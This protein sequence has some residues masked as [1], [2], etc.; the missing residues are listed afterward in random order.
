ML[1]ETE[2]NKDGVLMVPIHQVRDALDDMAIIAVDES[3]QKPGD[4]VAHG[5]AQILAAIAT[6]FNERVE[7]EA[8][9][10]SANNL[11]I[12]SPEDFL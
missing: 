2:F 5:Q 4:A 9:R 1:L 10:A 7:A 3:L 6:F 12:P 11:S 8:M